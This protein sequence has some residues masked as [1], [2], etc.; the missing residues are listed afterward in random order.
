MSW[1]YGSVGL[2]TAFFVKVCRLNPQILEFAHDTIQ[3]F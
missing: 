2:V 1:H 3:S